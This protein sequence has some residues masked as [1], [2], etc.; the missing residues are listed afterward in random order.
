MLNPHLI[1]AKTRMFLWIPQLCSIQSWNLR[2]SRTNHLVVIAC[3]WTQCTNLSSMFCTT[4]PSTQ[5][6]RNREQSPKKGGDCMEC[7]THCAFSR[8]FLIW[9]KK[10]VFTENIQKNRE[11]REWVNSDQEN[12]VLKWCN[13]LPLYNL[14]KNGLALI[15]FLWLKRF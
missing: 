6:R 11:T 1:L 10:I 3:L 15:L 9:R 7:S 8:F 2:K 13:F 14:D 5:S 12:W 4:Q